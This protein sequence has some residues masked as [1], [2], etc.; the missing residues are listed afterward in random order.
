MVFWDSPFKG[1]RGHGGHYIYSDQAI[2]I[3]RTMGLVFHQPLR[4]QQGLISSLVSLLNIPLD[5]PDYTV[6]SRR[7]GGLNNELNRLKSELDKSRKSGS[8]KVDMIV[9]STGIKIYGEGEWMRQ[10]HRTKTRQ[11]WRKLHFS[12]DSDGWINAMILTDHL[13]TGLL[14]CARFIKNDIHNV[15]F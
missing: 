4:Q 10:K 2:L 7:S 14:S 3:C 9:D 12:T 8:G 13:L 11:S 6:I 1:K 15:S 5:V